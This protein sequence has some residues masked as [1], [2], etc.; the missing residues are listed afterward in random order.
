ME[1]LG[2][3]AMVLI[4][5]SH[6]ELNYHAR[7]EVGADEFSVET[8]LAHPR[9]PEFPSTFAA[10]FAET[11]GLKRRR[12]EREQS[13]ANPGAVPDGDAQQD[14]TQPVPTPGWSFISMPLQQP[15]S[16]P[17]PFRG[18]TAH[19]GHARRVAERIGVD[20]ACP[21]LPNVGRA[22]GSTATVI[23]T[24]RVSMTTG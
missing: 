3:P 19:P 1:T 17:M 9:A 7:V 8:Q 24:R 16:R 15:R 4:K 11:R 2:V 18:Q 20:L 21:L 12:Q 14:E 5:V 22:A 6:Q 23:D 13:R 10:A